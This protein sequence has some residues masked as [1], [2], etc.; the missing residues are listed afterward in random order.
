MV[1]RLTIFA[2]GGR[3]YQCMTLEPIINQFQP[4]TLEEMSAIKLMNRTD[5]KFVTSVPVLARL[6]ELARAEYRAQQTAG[7]RLSPYRTLYFDT[8]E[9]D[10]YIAHQNGHLNRQK[11]RVRSYVSSGLHFLEVKTKDNHKRTHKKRVTLSVDDQQ[12][13]PALVQ[14]SQGDIS[15][16]LTQRLRYDHTTLVPTLENEFSRITLVNRACTERL[17][18]DTGLQFVNRVTR[19][20]REMTGLVII[21]LKRDGLQPSPIL[22]LLRQLRI[23]PHGFSKYCMGM[24]FT[25]PRLKQNRFKE[26]MRSVERIMAQC[27]Q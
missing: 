20:R 25:D 3:F 19:C 24:A 14:A 8:P 4:I 9:C 22:D 21:E 10:M 15:D 27:Q 18:I 23:K 17:T 13:W 11:V 12:A 2:P 16:F 1:A 26:R 7:T 5:T 6:L